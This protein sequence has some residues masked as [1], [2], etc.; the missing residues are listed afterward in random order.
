MNHYQKY[1]D[2]AGKGGFLWL[3]K[4]HLKQ[5]WKKPGQS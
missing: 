2:S 1:F 3:L 5:N 4:Q